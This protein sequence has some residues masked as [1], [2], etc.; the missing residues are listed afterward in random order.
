MLDSRFFTDYTIILRDLPLWGE[1]KTKNVARVRSIAV[2][3][4]V[5]KQVGRTGDRWYI[6]RPGKVDWKTGTD[7]ILCKTCFHTNSVFHRKS[8]SLKSRMVEERFY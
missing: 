8:Q 1:E 4:D 7:N 2:G 3:K 6:V 5:G